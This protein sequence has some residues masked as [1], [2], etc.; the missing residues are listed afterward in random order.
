MTTSGLPETGAP[1]SAPEQQ[2]QLHNKYVKLRP[3]MADDIP[4]LYLLETSEVLGPRWRFRGSTPGMD[5]WSGATWGTVL[6]S[7]IVL[8]ATKDAPIG[9]VATHEANFQDGHAKMSAANF[10]PPGN[11]HLAFIL[12][13]GL[14][15]DY[16]FRCWDL[17]K[18]YMEV[19]EYN[20]DQFASGAGRFF[21][22]EGR[23]RDHF[24]F[25]GRYW[26]QVILGLYREK[27]NDVRDDVLGPAES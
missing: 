9:L 13:I 11:R 18:L 19:P 1:G 12:G 4:S 15:L 21:E 14:F 5:R 23:L 10:M 24:F 8:D 20:Y 22:E 27:W 17:R 2:V 3:V 16:V 7:F 25:D 6:A 26:D